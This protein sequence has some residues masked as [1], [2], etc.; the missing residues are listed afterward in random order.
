M[1]DKYD[2]IE[3]KFLIG[4][5]VGMTIAIVAGLFGTFT[6]GTP[7]SVVFVTPAIVGLVITVICI[8]GLLIIMVADLSQW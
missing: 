2:N 5:M 8:I 3:S 4:M 1:Y 6:S 7:M